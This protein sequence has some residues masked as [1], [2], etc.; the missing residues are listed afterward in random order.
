MRSDITSSKLL[1]NIEKIL[2]M[3]LTYA[4][5]V[6]AGIHLQSQSF[7]K[8]LYKAPCDSSK[9]PHHFPVAIM[10]RKSPVKIEIADIYSFN[11]YPR[12]KDYSFVVPIAVP[13]NARLD[14][15]HSD[16]GRIKILRT[17][18]GGKQYL[19][20][21][22]MRSNRIASG[23]Y[24]ASERS[25]K[26]V[27]Y[28]QYNEIGVFALCAGFSAILNGLLWSIGTALYKR[29]RYRSLKMTS[30]AD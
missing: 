14:I 4:F 21:D 24:V 20:V 16:E 17:L 3:I 11:R 10:T 6:A 2:L 9:L 18:P 15:E 25:F 23:W 22:R 26:P 27:Y 1:K 7:E 5:I 28:Q 8:G 12:K 30:E 29:N 19:R 13:K